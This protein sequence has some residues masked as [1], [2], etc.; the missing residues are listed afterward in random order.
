MI[1]EFNGASFVVW[2]PPL[3][4]A[5]RAGDRVVEGRLFDA[6]FLPHNL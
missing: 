1:D 4:A 3:V 6:N 5:L 2:F